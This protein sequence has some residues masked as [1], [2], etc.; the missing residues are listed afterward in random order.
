MPVQNVIRVLI[1]DD[2]TDTRENIKRMLQFDSLIEVV[3]MARSGRE[4]IDLSNQVK[5]DVIIMDINMPDMDG[6]TATETIRRKLPYVQIVILSVQND[7]NYMRRAMQ[8]GVRDFLT[9]PPAIEDLT[10]AVRP[11]GKM[12]QDEKANNATSPGPS[13]Q[14]VSRR[15]TGKIITV[16]SPKGGTGC[17][18][19]ATNLA[20]ALQTEETPTVILE[21]N[22]LFG[23]VTVFL[24]EQVKNSIYDLTPRV[25]ELDAEVVMNV[26]IKHPSSG[27][28]ILPAPPKA[29]LAADITTDQFSKLLDFLRDVYAYIIVDTNAYLTDTV[30]AALEGSDLIILVTSQDIPSIKNCSSFLALADASGIKRNRILF[31]MNRYDKRNSVSPERVGETLR[32]P[33]ILSIPMD[34]KTVNFSITRGTP[35]V[36][37]GKTLPV[38]KSIFDLADLVHSRLDRNEDTIPLTA[39]R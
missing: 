22:L 27:L 3:G 13:S 12:A 25:D 1:V 37:S 20:V 36:I 35:F 4:A 9:K 39:K 31:V 8:A 38:S 15:G 19:L 33:I 14:S 30:Q 11:A 24:N 5:P 6:I 32:Q 2:I 18:T 29:E 21:A 23:D 34:E 7:P 17:T 28:S 16:Y 26:A 10:A